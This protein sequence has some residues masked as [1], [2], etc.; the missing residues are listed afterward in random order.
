MTTHVDP[1][2]QP[3]P[4]EGGDHLT[5]FRWALPPTQPSRGVVLL[6]HGLGEHAGRYQAVA[7]RLLA[8]GFE[9]RAYDQYGHGLSSGPRGVL[10]TSERLL[11]DLG[12][13][14]A[15][16]RTQMHAAQPLVLLGHSMGGCVSARYVSLQPEAVQAL[17][18][19]SPA[20][21]IGL[22][23]AQRGLLKFLLRWAP[24]LTIGNGLKVRKIS[25]D[26]AVV[27]AYKNDPLVH[28]RVCARLVQFMAQA[29]PAVLDAART[30]RVPTLLLFAQDDALVRPQGSRD[31][32]QAAPQ[33]VVQAHEFAALYHEIFNE[34]EPQAVFTAL[35]DWLT[36]R[37]A[38]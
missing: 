33:G 12:R 28:G 29:G 9:V 20:L 23:S 38:L 17:V 10:P 3:L 11:E 13:V 8:W 32:A 19:S 5:L 27:E 36:Q 16:T 26:Q 7:Q 14:I 15:H 6:V 30:W 35:Q 4:C 22:S 37:F 34:L 24:E 31:F 1:Q 25:H 18:L 21:D 2:R